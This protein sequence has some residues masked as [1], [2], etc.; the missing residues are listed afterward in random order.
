MKEIKDYYIIVSEYGS[1]ARST[2]T[3]EILIIK[4]EQYDYKPVSIEN[5]KITLTDFRER[6]DVLDTREYVVLKC[7]F[8]IKLTKDLKKVYTCITDRRKSL[9]KDINTLYQL[10]PKYWEPILINLVPR[11]EKKLKDK[12][13][14]LSEREIAK[15]LL[16]IIEEI[17]P[18]IWKE[19]NENR[20]SKCL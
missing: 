19:E 10:S 1:S 5:N 8:I 6:V 18:I 4:K 2:K 3:A 12:R 7:R 14:Q 15:N 9:N 16:E 13:I 20:N 11:L 17:D